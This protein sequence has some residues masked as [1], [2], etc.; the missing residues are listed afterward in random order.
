MEN[1]L[2]SQIQ[3]GFKK[4]DSCINQLLSIAYNIYQSLDQGYGVRRVFL[5]IPKAFDDARHKGFITKLKQ[6]GIGGPLLKVLTDF[7]KSRKQRVVLNGQYLSWRDVF[8]GV[9][10]GSI[11]GALVSYLNQ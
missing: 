9:P 2:M 1:G 3:S 6:N 8:A 11:L 4:G 7:L 10:Q 5:N